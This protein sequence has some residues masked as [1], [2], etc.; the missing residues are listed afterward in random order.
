[1]PA[2]PSPRELPGI[3]ISRSLNPVGPKGEMDQYNAKGVPYFSPGFGEPWVLELRDS[4]L[5]EVL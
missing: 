2:M 1:M 3:P 4:N 5:E